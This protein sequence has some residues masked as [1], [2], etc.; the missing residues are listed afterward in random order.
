VE[1]Q[2]VASGDLKMRLEG[3]MGFLFLFF[4]DD[5]DLVFGRFSVGVDDE[6]SSL[7]FNPLGEAIFFFLGFFFFFSFGF[8]SPAA[9]ASPS[10][11]DA[12]TITASTAAAGEA[13]STKKAEEKFLNPL[14]RDEV[15]VTDSS[16]DEEVVNPLLL[17]LSKVLRINDDAVRL[18]NV[19][20]NMRC[21][22][23]WEEGRLLE[24]A[25]LVE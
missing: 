21:A 22:A 7:A 10:E 25:C 14:D 5:A 12:S 9:I 13:S 17:V 24:V 1:T 19:F 20:D 4:L 3:L 2:V 15:L 16:E 6:S 8:S 11:G 23:G 18:M